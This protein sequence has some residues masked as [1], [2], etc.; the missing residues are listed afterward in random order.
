M[1][2]SGYSA[3]TPYLYKPF[4]PRAYRVNVGDGFILRAI[5]R[6]IGKVAPE[7]LFPAHVNPPA[8]QYA[9]LK[10][11]KF[12][13]LAGANQLQDN[14]SP[15]KGLKAEQ[16]RAE[17]LRFVPFGVG[18]SGKPGGGLDLTEDAKDVLRALH[19][20][21]EF[22]SWRCPR[23]VAAL[24][25]ALPELK[26]RFLMTCCPVVLDTPLM[27]G[28]A[29]MEGDRTIAVTIT[30]RD[31][32]WDR[33]MPMLHRLAERFPKARR[34]LVLHNDYALP[35]VTVSRLELLR[36]PRKL[37]GDVLG[38]RSLA[39]KLGYEVYI[40]KTADEALAFYRNSVDMHFGSRLHA[41]LL[42]LSWNKKSFLVSVDERMSG[43]SE[44]LGF[45]LCDPSNI[46][47]YLN[48]DFEIVRSQ[49]RKADAV[50]Q[51]FTRY[52]Q[53]LA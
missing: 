27:Q 28:K 5:E 43:F 49:A 12:T 53:T 10:N 38:A 34:V 25:K 15:W 1:M 30:D 44:Y 8:D 48:F 9:R 50:M 45:P 26:G 16:I 7:L 32:F 2:I 40:P 52:L 19:E 46:D 35:L 13:V 14:F 11:S 31:D 20:K 36:P 51:T 24:E 42:M 29:F 21:I 6:K 23:T 39:R 33:E 47:G 3:L 4:D 41:H 17:N 18:I 37:A 22:S